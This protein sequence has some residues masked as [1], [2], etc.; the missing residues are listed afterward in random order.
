MKR[1]QGVG[2]IEVVFAIAVLGI[3]L[4]AISPLFANYAKINRESQYRTDAVAVA[5]QTL[6]GMRQ[7][8]F[9]NWPAQGVTTNVSTGGGTY[10]VKVTYCTGNVTSLCSEGARHTRV[11]VS[12]G[13]K[14]YYN[15][16]TVYTK[17]E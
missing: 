5:E 8:D 11:E 2:L 6:D 16:E 1:S 12:R 17:F 10:Q 14:T 7:K 15:V 3:V 9:A 13:G 4:G